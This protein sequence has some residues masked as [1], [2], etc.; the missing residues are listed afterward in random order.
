MNDY[1]ELT[2]LLRAL[3]DIHMKHVDSDPNNRMWHQGRVVGLEDAI[4]AIT[5]YFSPL[6]DSDCHWVDLTNLPKRVPNFHF[7]PGHE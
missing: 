7:D 6:K 3:R 5:T 1:S 2:K 4:E